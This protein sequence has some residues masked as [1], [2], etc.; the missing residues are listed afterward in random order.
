MWLVW[1]RS[2]ALVKSVLLI[3]PLI[4]AAFFI[5]NGLSIAMAAFSPLVVSALA[6]GLVLAHLL[7]IQPQIK[8]ST[9]PQWRGGVVMVAIASIVSALFAMIALT[10][11]WQVPIGVDIVLVSL[12]RI[13]SIGGAACDIMILALLLVRVRFGAAKQVL[14]C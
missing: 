6:A 8:S 1:V 9:T 3:V 14:G 13:A 2:L 7:P 12:I 5:S 4:T 10:W 11:T